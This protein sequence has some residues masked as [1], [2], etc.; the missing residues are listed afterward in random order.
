MK[1][2]ASGWGK[3][4][5]FLFVT[6]LFSR[7]YVAKLPRPHMLGVDPADGLYVRWKFTF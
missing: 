3:A 7:R 2:E 1:R 6:N 5:I 4:R